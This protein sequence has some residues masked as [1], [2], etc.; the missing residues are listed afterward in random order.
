M[1]AFCG[2]AAPFVS[3]ILFP[4]GEQSTQLCRYPG[5][6]IYLFPVRFRITSIGFFRFTRQLSALMQPKRA[7]H[8]SEFVCI[9]AC[10]LLQIVSQRTRTPAPSAA[11]SS[12]ATRA[13]I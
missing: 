8:A 6:M 4:A 1:G 9:R 10:L 11:S 12:V 2:L 7:E 13:S 5:Q 3:T